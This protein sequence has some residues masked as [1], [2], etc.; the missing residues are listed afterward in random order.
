[1]DLLSSCLSVPGTWDDRLGTQDLVNTI[2]LIGLR[3]IDNTWN[4]IFE[5][6]IRTIIAGGMRLGSK[7]CSSNN[8]LCS[9]PSPLRDLT[10]PWESNLSL[11][12]LL[13]HRATSALP[14][15]GVWDVLCFHFCFAPS[16]LEVSPVG[17]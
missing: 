16:D 17:L 11:S 8:I 1:M 10:S 5:L 15:D 6:N 3:F 12:A 13:L 4:P 14:R 2:I 9:H 7:S